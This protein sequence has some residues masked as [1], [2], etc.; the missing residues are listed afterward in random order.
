MSKGYGEQEFLLDY[1][2]MSTASNALY[3]SADFQISP[4]SVIYKQFKRAGLLPLLDRVCWHSVSQHGV[5]F[6]DSAVA[7][8][9]TLHELFDWHCTSEGWSFWNFV[10]KKVRT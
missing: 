3:A 1:G 9:A 8:N 5:L 6:L 7:D 10:D 4:N 2:M